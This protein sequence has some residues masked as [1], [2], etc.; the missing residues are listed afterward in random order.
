MYTTKNA[1]KKINYPPVDAN[2]Q[3][4]FQNAQPVKVIYNLPSYVYIH[5]SDNIQIALWDVRFLFFNL[6]IS[7]A[8]SS[9]TLK[10]SASPGKRKKFYL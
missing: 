10:T 6:R 7:K 4:N 2:G 3:L 9:I 5:P 8:G 1:L